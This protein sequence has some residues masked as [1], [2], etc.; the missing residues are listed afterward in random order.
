MIL[1]DSTNL[2]LNGEEN[3]CCVCSYNTLRM[4]KIG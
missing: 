2:E 1:N 3:I 4:L